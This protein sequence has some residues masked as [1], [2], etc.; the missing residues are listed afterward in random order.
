MNFRVLTKATKEI[1]S[2]SKDMLNSLKKEDK[3]AYLLG[4]IDS[5]NSLGEAYENK[6]K[7]IEE[8][9]NSITTLEEIKNEL[10]SELKQIQQTSKEAMILK[11][12]MKAKLTCTQ[13]EIETLSVKKEETEK[14]AEQMK[15]KYIKEYTYLKKLLSNKENIALLEEREKRQ[16]RLNALMAA[17]ITFEEAVDKFVKE[18]FEIKDSTPEALIGDELVKIY[19]SGGIVEARIELGE[20]TYIVSI[21][22]NEDSIK[23]GI[24]DKVSGEPV[25]IGR[26]L[27]FN[28]INWL[29]EEHNNQ[30]II[31]L[32]K[33]IKA[34]KKRMNAQDRIP[35]E[36]KLKHLSLV[37]G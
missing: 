34:F 24:L 1:F 36:K 12:E 35:N 5:L 10:E 20:D 8:L 16:K 4:K 15:S 14:E 9:A 27:N 17:N 22:S 23:I 6:K 37:A 21:S 28:N 25:L 13:E 29:T 26:G 31:Q 30:L 11:I 19:E 2:F 18:M 3:L 33:C 7:E 32:Y